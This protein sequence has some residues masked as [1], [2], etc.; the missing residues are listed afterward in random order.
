MRQ[1]AHE[2]RY[3]ITGQAREQ[4]CAQ[5][6]TRGSLTSKCAAP[7]PDRA[8]AGNRADT[9][10]E[11]ALRECAQVSDLVIDAGQQHRLIEQD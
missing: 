11:Q 3:Q 8:D 7:A 4:R 10:R 9:D 6:C 5:P 2:S 1:L